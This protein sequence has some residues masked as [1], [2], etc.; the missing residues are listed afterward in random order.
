[1]FGAG[2]AARAIG[3]VAQAVEWEITVV[4][5]S[6]ERG[7]ELTKLLNDKVPAEADFAH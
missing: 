1:M 4:N 6:V 3:V 5:R 7:E 2:G